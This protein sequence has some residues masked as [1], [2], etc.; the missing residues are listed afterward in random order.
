MNKVYY[1]FSIL[2]TPSTRCFLRTTLKTQILNLC[3]R[4]S[5][6]YFLRVCIILLLY[7]CIILL[8]STTF[9]CEIFF[10]FAHFDHILSFFFA[11]KNPKPNYILVEY[12]FLKFYLI[13][14]LKIGYGSYS[15][16]ITSTLQK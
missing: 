12:T 15:T 4:T 9:H 2:S 7:F 6:T 3:L 11:H 16:I 1:F 14:L 5:W 10:F 8:T 13:F